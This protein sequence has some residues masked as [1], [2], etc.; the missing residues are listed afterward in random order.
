MPDY[1]S[2]RSNKYLIRKRAHKCKTYFR[3]KDSKPI[4][5]IAAHTFKVYAKEYLIHQR[6]EGK[7]YIK[8]TIL[9]TVGV[10]IRD[11]NFSNH[12]VPDMKKNWQIDRF[13][14]KN[15]KDRRICIPLFSPSISKEWGFLSE[16]LKRTPKWYQDPDLW[17]WF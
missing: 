6:K 7:L 13:G 8:T 11:R 4:L 9:N 2:H 17:G 1:F 15:C 10:K 5:F 12:T 3:Q 16:I 14:E